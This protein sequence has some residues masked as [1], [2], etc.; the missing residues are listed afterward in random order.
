MVVLHHESDAISDGAPNDGCIFIGPIRHPP[1]RAT[2]AWLLH[3]G[4]SV[5]VNFVK[6]AAAAQAAYPDISLDV[7]DH[8]RDEGAAI[9][10]AD[11]AILA[12]FPQ[13]S[14]SPTTPYSVPHRQSPLSTNLSV[15]LAPGGIR[16]SLSPPGNDFNLINSPEINSP[17]LPTPPS[18][19]PT[20]PIAELPT[21]PFGGGIVHTSTTPTDPPSV[22]CA[23]RLVGGGL[24]L[25]N[26][27]GAPAVGHTGVGP[28]ASVVGYPHGG[29][30]GSTLHHH[31]M[32]AP[33]PTIH[34]GSD[35]LAGGFPHHHHPGGPP[36][37]HTRA[38]M[39]P[40]AILATEIIP[41]LPR[42]GPSWYSAPPYAA[43]P[44]WFP[45]PPATQSHPST[46]SVPPA[47]ASISEPASQPS[48][49]VA[50]DCTFVSGKGL[51]GT[52]GGEG[53]GGSGG[54]SGGT[55]SG[56]FPCPPMKRG[57]PSKPS[58]RTCSRLMVAASLSLNG[59]HFGPGSL[60]FCG[61]LPT[62]PV[63]P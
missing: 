49:S 63:A 7:G 1:T 59:Q 35:S 9:L 6:D 50:D 4:Y 47:V 8:V 12:P 38:P 14:S 44:S 15:A 2:L 5:R 45:A 55:L 52:G 13:A 16:G 24:G 17:T 60:Q 11:P 34:A 31:P 46:I 32:G 51:D 40:G 27:G 26:S 58:P 53:G 43:A 61:F 3:H 39:E 48:T 19:T 56:S 23:G 54:G 22:H 18:S 33:P 37:H 62:L 29:L 25:A 42:F 41:Y 21:A 28:G 36:Q 20:F 30:V 10:A 57:M